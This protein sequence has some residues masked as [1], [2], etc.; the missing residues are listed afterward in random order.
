ML[1]INFNKNRLQKR[2]YIVALV[3]NDNLDSIYIH[4]SEKGEISKRRV[5]I[6]LYIQR[7]KF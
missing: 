1:N 2:L 7:H 3:E 5:L 6:K 4:E